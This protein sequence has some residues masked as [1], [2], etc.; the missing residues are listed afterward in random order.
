MTYDTLKSRIRGSVMTKFD[1]DFS[2]LR[3]DLTW[4][5]RKPAPQAQVI[6]R[7]ADVR[8]VQAAVQFAAE[9]GLT[10]SARGGGHHFSGIA[11][12]A[13]MVIDLRALD[14]MRIDAASRIAVVEPAVTNLRLA[15]ALAQKGLAFPTG[16]CGGVAVSGYLLGGGIG[17]NS[18]AWGV[19]CFSVLAVDVVMADGQLVTATADEHPDIFWAAR[20]AG[21][22]FFGIVT[23]YRL[24]LY[25]APKAAS[26][27]VRIY[28][29]SAL[30]A[31][32]DWT[33]ALASRLPPCVE[34]TLK[35]VR[36][37]TGPIIVAIANVFAQDPDEAAQI[38]ADL[39]R[40][41]PAGA[42]EV[43][44]AMPAPIPTLYEMT[45]QSTPDGARY[46][47]DCIWSNGDVHEALTATLRA[48]ELAP[49]ALSFGLVSLHAN[50]VETPKTAAFSLTGRLFS[51]L[52]GV[53]ES[54]E[55]D[56]ENLAW[57]RNS[58]LRCGEFAS[59]SYVGEADL[60]HPTLARPTLERAAELRL[61]TLSARYDPAGLF[62]A[63]ARARRVVAA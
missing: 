61:R 33:E 6:V 55:D 56:A 52:Y 29:A 58:I 44:P 28:P 60:E 32:A 11:A 20:G 24:R 39:G 15:T 10:V 23:A 43:I 3:D 27:L 35:T 36:T 4:N 45:A 17:W 62:A 26:A 63:S 1:P 53:W 47:V 48:I 38:G 34:F 2:H 42:L 8:D 12:R 22:A 19:A 7:A 5:G 49:S 59:G 50:A 41:A 18:N 46:G 54:A 25:E 16:H 13:E 9:Y 51:T 21:P 57:L 37:P 14:N 30:S 31:V 40:D